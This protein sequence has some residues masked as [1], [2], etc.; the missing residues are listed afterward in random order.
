[1]YFFQLGNGLWMRATKIKHDLLLEKEIETVWLVTSTL[2]ITLQRNIVWN[3]W[4]YIFPLSYVCT[5]CFRRVSHF[6]ERT[7]CWF[8]IKGKSAILITIFSTKKNPLVEEMTVCFEP[9]IILR[10]LS[11]QTS[12]SEQ[13]NTFSW[14]HIYLP[15]CIKWYESPA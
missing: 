6:E 8:L 11:F 15:C 12:H 1:M 9:W 2:E 13:G 5:F 4:A 7:K 3:L 14:R 10:P